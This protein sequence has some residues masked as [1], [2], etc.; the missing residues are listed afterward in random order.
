VIS[1]LRMRKITIALIALA[2][3]VAA[4]ASAAAD[5]SKLPKPAKG[6]ADGHKGFADGH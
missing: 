4:P 5:S 1:L 6:F 2:L 3:F